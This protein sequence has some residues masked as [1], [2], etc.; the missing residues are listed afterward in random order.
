MW[1]IATYAGIWISAMG[2]EASVKGLLMATQKAVKVPALAPRLM[3]AVNLIGSLY[4]PAYILANF[5]PQDCQPW[6]LVFKINMHLFF[7]CFDSFLVFKTWAVAQ[8]RPTVAVLGG[9]LLAHRAIWGILDCIKSFG[10]MDMETGFCLYSQNQLSAFGFLLG[11][12]LT[13][14]FC[15]ALTVWSAFRDAEAS[16]TRIQ[17]LYG[18]LIADNV[19]RTVMI[20]SVN[21]LIAYY[22]A[23]G[24]LTTSKTGADVLLIL[25]A[26][27][28]YVYTLALNAEFVWMSMRNAVMND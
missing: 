20:L 9:V 6:S 17:K 24:A 10:F 16:S 1:K 8:K 28:Y 18:I 26:L 22:A 13:D 23:Y 3:V 4:G 11:D 12:L 7:L 15:T 14:M 21:L 27:S 5:M 19:I 25:P 2:M